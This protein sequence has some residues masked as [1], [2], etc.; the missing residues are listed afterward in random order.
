[1]SASSR[2]TRSQ[3]TGPSCMAP[4]GRPEGWSSW[5]A[6][7]TMWGAAARRG[8]HKRAGRPWHLCSLLCHVEGPPWSPPDREAGRVRHWQEWAGEFSSSQPSGATAAWTGVSCRQRRPRRGRTVLKRPSSLSAAML[9]RTEKGW[10]STHRHR[11][12][13]AETQGL[14]S[15]EML[16]GKAAAASAAPEPGER[17]LFTAQGCPALGGQRLCSVTP[18]PQSQ[19]RSGRR[20]VLRS[21]RE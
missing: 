14:S 10:P 18:Q 12:N 8:R 6:E 3:R 15:S 5:R 11:S 7:P 9:S 16:P 4:C 20:P 2:L 19:S 1:M 13:P 21:I 17:R